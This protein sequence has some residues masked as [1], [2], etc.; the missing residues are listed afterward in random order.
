MTMTVKIG[1]VG[2]SFAK[3]AYLPAIK[4]IPEDPAARQRHEISRIPFKMK[5]ILKYLSLAW[6]AGRAR[7]N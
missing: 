3:A 7:Q 5:D 2:A 6:P 4:N 1:I